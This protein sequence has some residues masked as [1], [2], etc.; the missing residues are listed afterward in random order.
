MIDTASE[1]EFRQKIKKLEQKNKQLETLLVQCS[2]ESE[3]LKNRL[4]TLT[5][6]CSCDSVHHREWLQAI[7]QNIPGVV[8]Q[9]YAK[10]SG[11]VGAN[12][13]SPK[14]YEIFGIEFDENPSRFLERFTQHIH[15][16]DQQS[17]SNSFRLAIEEQ[18]P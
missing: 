17:W 18:R 7:T 10:S 12:Y 14:L 8:F 3:T 13:A 1:T 16:E 2:K 11:E 5:E 15:P 6:Q 4:E 9:F